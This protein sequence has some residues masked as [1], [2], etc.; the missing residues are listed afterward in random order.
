MSESAL[1]EWAEQ[2]WDWFKGGMHGDPPA[3]PHHHKPAP[4]TPPVPPTPTPTPTPTPPGPVTLTVAWHN[5][6]TAVND[7]DVQTW[8]DGLNAQ[9]PDIQALWPHVEEC[10][11]V[12]VPKGQTAPAGAVK[13]TIKPDLPEAP[14]ALGYHDVTSGGEPFIVIGSQTCIQ[15][16][17]S[18]SSCMSHEA[19]ELTV[20]PGCAATAVAPNGDVWALEVGDPVESDSYDVT[21]PAGAVQMSDLVGQ[22]FFNDGDSA[23]DKTGNAS[24]SFK[25]APGGYAIINGRQV[26][27]DGRVV[28]HGD[29]DDVAAAAADGYH[30]AGVPKAKLAATRPVDQP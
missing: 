6:D 14:G 22:N 8:V 28:D 27:A 23:L 29:P 30:V 1:V 13:A 3:P 11:H 17:V 7:S 24:E 20:D 9:V 10:T 12:F 4:P 21:T 25:I 2:M 5:E 18:I 26:F 15:A 16:G 19:C